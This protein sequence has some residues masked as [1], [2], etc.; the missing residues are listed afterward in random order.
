M[1]SN[2][3]AFEA[4]KVKDESFARFKNEKD[5][6]VANLPLNPPPRFKRDLRGSEAQGTHSLLY[7]V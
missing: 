3:R 6:S 5:E 1:N 4:T 2:A 7:L